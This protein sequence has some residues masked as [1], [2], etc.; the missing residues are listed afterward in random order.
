MTLDPYEIPF[1]RRLLNHHGL[2]GMEVPFLPQK[3]I[4]TLLLDCLRPYSALAAI[5]EQY[6]YHSWGHFFLLEEH[7]EGR[8]RGDAPTGVRAPAS[9]CPGWR[10]TGGSRG[11]FPARAATASAQNE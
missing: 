9:S 3:R 7:K 8:V 2:L 4:P 6:H 11:P 1:P 10:N 5:E